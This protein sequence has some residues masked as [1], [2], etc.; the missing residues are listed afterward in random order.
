MKNIAVICTSLSST[1]FHD[2]FQGIRECAIA[3][4]SNV[5]FFCV[6]RMV[7]GGGPYERGEYNIFNV[8]DY[9]GFDGV[10]LLS[11]T[12][13]EE[14]NAQEVAVKIAEAGIPTVSVEGN[15]PSMYN[16]KIDNR[17][18]MYQMVHH[19]IQDHG[20][21]R[22]NFVTGPL[23]SLEAK[24]R[25][26]GYRDAMT[27]AGI[28]FEDEQVYEGDYMPQSGRDAAV[29]FLEQSGPMPEAIVCSNDFMAMGVNEYLSQR[30]IKIPDQIA[31]S[32]FDDSPQVKFMEPRLTTVSRENYKAGYAACAKLLTDY[33]P[34][35]AGK[36]KSLQT[37]VIKRESCGCESREEFDQEKLRK[38]YFKGR[39]IQSFFLLET[40]KMFADMSEVK[41]LEALCEV[42]KPHVAH[43]KC[44]DF[45]LCLSNEWQGFR[46]NQIL[47]NRPS[48]ETGAA[49]YITEGYGTGTYLAYSHASHSHKDYANFGIT[50][51]LEGLQ[52]KSL[53][54]NCY[55]VMPVHFA[56]RMFGFC[57]V[58]N[59]DYAFENPL[60][61]SWIQNIGYGLESVR[62][63][64]LISTLTRK[65]DSLWIYDNL[66]GL[67][68]RDGFNK[69]ALPVWMEC[70]GK[71]EEVAL[72]FV[73]MDELKNVNDKYG[74]DA[75]DRYI[76]AIATILKKRKRHGEVIMRFEGEEFVILASGLKE[77]EAGEYC[78]RIYAEVEDYNKMHNLPVSI[79]VMIGYYLTVP[80]G[81]KGLDLAIEAA[82]ARRYEAKREK[83]TK[84]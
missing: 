37:N 61:Q 10:I 44:D 29:Y 6:D 83:E 62:K 23:S 39:D 8:T 84:E 70:A 80:D 2:C 46:A 30:G 11:N 22:I 66:T 33:D 38:T 5:F 27:D 9:K 69:Y 82:D 15:Y 71:Q 56:D 18:A 28:D 41:T 47:N 16:F 19:F 81:A 43:M 48:E 54:R 7:Q 58:S 53:G 34:G 3:N 57:I 67:Y 31:L 64:N 65:L 78:D 68:N 72:F 12:F 25:Y 73:D 21:K 40:R 51:L 14:K 49:D 50:Q 75:G 59:S 13:V 24:E 77:E 42:L 79:S 55:V 63:E 20:F 45:Y 26:A 4:N 60:F 17:R 32:G 35:E 52:E 74:H 1:A 76:K 36:V